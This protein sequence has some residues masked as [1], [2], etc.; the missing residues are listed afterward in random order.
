[1]DTYRTFKELV[2]IGGTGTLRDEIDITLFY[3][4]GRK[5]MRSNPGGSMLQNKHGL[6]KKTIPSQVLVVGKYVNN[7]VG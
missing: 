2:D 6:H 5:G 4:M 3:S 1:M 7:P